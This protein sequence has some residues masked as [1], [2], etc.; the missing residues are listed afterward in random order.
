MTAGPL[1]RLFATDAP[2]DAGVAALLDALPGGVGLFGID[3]TLRFANRAYLELAGEPAGATTQELLARTPPEDRDEVAGFWSRFFSDDTPSAER[4]MRAR[5]SDGTEVWVT[6]QARK[7][8]GADGRPVGV[9]MSW[10]DVTA[11]KRAEAAAADAGRYFE[12]LMARSSDFVTV[13]EVDGSWRSSSESAARVLGYPRGFDPAGGVFSLVHPDDLPRA[14][15]G[16]ARVLDGEDFVG[17]PLELRIRDVHGE[18]RRL[19][20][21]AANQ[22][23]DPIVRGVVINARDVTA[24]RE[25][26]ERLAVSEARYRDLVE[27]MDE[28]VWVTDAQGATTY[29]NP[30]MAAMLSMPAAAMIGTPVADY[31][32]GES[33][34]ALLDWRARWVAGLAERHDL[35]FRRADGAWVW[36]SLT[37]TVVFA[38]GRPHTVIAVVS[39]ISDRKVLEAEL[40][41][42][43]VR[44]EAASEAKTA[45]VGRI[46]HEL[47]TPLHTILASLEL[48]PP[49]ETTDRHVARAASA[50]GHLLDLVGDLLDVARIGSRDLG[51]EREPVGVDSVLDAA[52]GLANLDGDR[53]VRTGVDGCRVLVDERRTIQVL[54]NLLANA[55]EHAP[56]GT[57][58]TV[59][60]RVVG[61][62]IEITVADLG[63]G[64]DPAVRDRVFEPLVTGSGDEGGVGL[65][66]A[67][68]RGLA[69]A[70]GGTLVAVDRPV[71]AAFVL[72]L[73]AVV[74]VADGPDARRVLYVEDDAMNVELVERILASRPGIELR[75]ER[76]VAAGIAAV[77]ADPPDVVLLDLHLPDGTG[78]DVIAALADDPRTAAV[79]VVVVT[80]DA[81]A[82]TATAVA[83]VGAGCLTKPF[84]IADLFAVID[85]PDGSGSRSGVAS[86]GSGLRKDHLEDR[87]VG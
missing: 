2:P 49:A 55:A 24:R 56:P 43:R 83:G 3:G 1:D 11:T 13:L 86:T 42:A 41:A 67:I 16:F 10:V 33:L 39:D 50:A 8:F 29:V 82:R 81:T 73:P 48:I 87:T 9:V 25:A 7:V 47:R 69:E 4:E 22:V 76:T 78:F 15:D 70:M 58:V 30:R 77:R 38:D 32:D 71:G 72:G 63:P 66:L 51:L 79:P 35:R 68:S 61:D 17:A 75:V 5:T 45:M 60:R 46:S 37:T 57:A 36:A 54:V 31:L 20:L 85:A 64:L 62:R 34:A 12:A 14:L 52:V 74:T 53:I 19:E 40:E 65:G 44:A 6:E 27:L 23:D 18:W 21:V 28:G 26:E 80:A 84:T 59:D